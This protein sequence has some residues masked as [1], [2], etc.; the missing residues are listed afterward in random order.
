MP[1]D[2]PTK[3]TLSIK[4]LVLNKN[5]TVKKL[6]KDFEYLKDMYQDEYFPDVLVD[7]VKNLIKEVVTYLECGQHSTDD[8]QKS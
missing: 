6:P 1:F 3:L 8:V 2:L 5:N 4:Q 7:K